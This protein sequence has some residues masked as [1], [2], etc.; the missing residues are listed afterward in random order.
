MKRTIIITGLLLIA[1][2]I[3]QGQKKT[4][5]VDIQWGKAQKESRRKTLSDIAGYDETGIYAVKTQKKDITLEHYDND[6]N[7]INSVE[8]NLEYQGKDREYE[9]IVQLNNELF[10][11]TSFKNRKQKRNYL[12]VQGINKKTLQLKKEVRI[13]AEIKFSGKWKY[14][15][16]NFDYEISRDSTKVL[17]Y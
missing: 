12:F 7:S 14:N 6:M 2:L 13:L 5:K 11:F 15:A 9:F 17:V 4:E 8:I 16:G 1:N 10:L 3:S